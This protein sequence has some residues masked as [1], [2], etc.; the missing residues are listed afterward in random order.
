MKKSN[1]I[2]NA[3]EG[4]V[5]NRRRESAAVKPGFAHKVLLMALCAL[6]MLTQTGC[7]RESTGDARA[8]RESADRQ[9]YS[10]S[11]HERDRAGA[12]RASDGITHTVAAGQSL[13][14][15]KDIYG[16][17]IPAIKK[18]NPG[19]SENTPLKI[20]QKV[21]IPGSPSVLA[22]RRDSYLK[23]RKNSG[24]SAPETAEEIEKLNW[25]VAGTVLSK[26]S[27]SSKG[28]YIKIAPG[29]AVKAVS[30]GEVVYAGKMKG[31]GNLI[32]IDHLNGLF[33]IY[34]LNAKNLAAKG[35]AV[36][37]GAKIAIGGDKITNGYSKLYFEL[38]TINSATGE[39][40]SVDPLKYLKAAK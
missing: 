17:S 27:P 4:A 30:H 18:H 39:P 21:F 31:Y 33:S 12:E 10:D 8:P 20:G 23:T 11:S 28:I 6:V 7:R 16:I 26:F 29:A 36:K 15:L 32:I 19:V 22:A 24:A 3:A 2:N 5:S 38:R 1:S 37:T 40:E 13:I 25:P 14:A 35:E 9:Y 34:G